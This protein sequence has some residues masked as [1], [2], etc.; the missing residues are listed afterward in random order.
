MKHR[1]ATSLLALGLF[2]LL[3]ETSNIAAQVNVTTAHQDIPS[4]ICSGTGCV[5]RTG[6]NL[7][8]NTLVFST[9]ADTNFGL[10]CSYEILTARYM[11]SRLWSR[12]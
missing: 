11:P 6:Q 7:A 2:L 5:Y 1:H 8:E 9:I 3:V 12:T 10:Y 4:T